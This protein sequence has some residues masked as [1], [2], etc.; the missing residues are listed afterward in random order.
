MS[1]RG[2]R[3]T[4][5]RNFLLF[6]LALAIVV[7]AT[8]RVRYGGGDPYQ[9]LSTT[10]L[11][12]DSQLEQVLSYK[13][14]IGNVAVS[15]QGR[16]FF[17]VHPESRPRGNKLLEWVDGAAI[18]YP[19]GTVQPHLFQT[20]LGL[21]IDRQDRLWTIDHGNHGFGTARLLAFDLASG[22]IVHDHEF[23]S[24]IAPAG[25]LLQDL[26]VSADGDTVF[27]A[28]ASLWRKR[29]AIIVYDIATRD[30]RRVLESHVSVS[31]QNYLIR[32]PIRDMSFLNGL[33]NLRTG[34]DGLALDVENKWLYFAAMNHGGLFRVPVR[35]LKNPVLA[36]R[37]L[38]NVVERYSDKPISDGLSA[39]L[40]G[41]IYITDV[42]HGAVLL[43]D[44]QSA[45][46]TMVKSTRI[47][48]A[49][50]LSFGPDG[51]LYLADSALPEQILQS[52]GHIGAAGPYF[53]FR[54]QPG[55]SGIPGQ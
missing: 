20:V 7:V 16:L 35:D 40:S 13:E 32:N 34:V 38:A 9:D 49:D 27:I 50:G 3:P 22:N 1:P 45:L 21:V 46:H 15:R 42:E 47:R 43:A 51:W 8:L 37:Q 52:K 6:L 14:P 24:D 19:N 10:P 11:L 25:S 48:W 54:F 2:E 18:P 17:T 29:A 4:L 5:L 44:R 23:R 55:F 12:D 39:D 30:A 31:A 28:D 26:Q 53:I 41:N 33:V 36:S